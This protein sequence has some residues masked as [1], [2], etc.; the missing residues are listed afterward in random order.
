MFSP[1]ATGR[2][3]LDAGEKARRRVAQPPYWQEITFVTVSP[4]MPAR[5][6]PGDA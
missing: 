3:V 1:A 4:A 2:A 6:R 5:L